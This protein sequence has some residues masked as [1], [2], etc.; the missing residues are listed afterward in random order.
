M[1]LTKVSIITV[2]YNNVE[3]IKNAIQSVLSQD[4]LNI[5]YIVIDGNSNDGTISAIKEFE[6][7]IDYFFSS[8]DKGIYDALNKGIEIST[9]EIIGILHSD[10]LFI[11]TK[12]VSE[13]VSKLQSEDAEFIFSDLIIVNPETKKIIRYYMANYFK[14]WMLRIGW[15]P[16]HPTVFMKKTIYDEFGDYSLDYEIASDFDYFLKIFYGRKIHWTYL[17]RITVVMGS[18]GVS[19]SGISNKILMAKEIRHSLKKNKVWSLSIFQ[20]LRYF[21]RIFELLIKPKIKY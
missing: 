16:P 15:V 4:Y 21:I 18:K 1:N 20:L 9:G 14:P 7:Q 2:V 17:N 8:S 11:D 5:E 6:D 10:D 12:V 3:Y 13:M 19:N